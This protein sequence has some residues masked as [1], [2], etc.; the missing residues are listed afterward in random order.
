MEQS[1]FF[2]EC[3]AEHDVSEGQEYFGEVPYCGWKQVYVGRVKDG[4]LGGSAV[5]AADVELVVRDLL[6]CEE[7]SVDE[8]LVS[9]LFDRDHRVGGVVGVYTVVVVVLGFPVGV[10]RSTVASWAP[11]VSSVHH[12]LVFS[13]SLNFYDEDQVMQEVW[14]VENLFHSVENVASVSQFSKNC[15]SRTVCVRQ[16]W[17]RSVQD[18][19]FCQS[20][21]LV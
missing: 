15:P 10:S 4:H 1:Y 17:S 3:V 13:E 5:S 16:L 21:R 19:M 7:V 12:R 20:K 9:V 6:L 8:V 18:P 11:D 14:T 2:G